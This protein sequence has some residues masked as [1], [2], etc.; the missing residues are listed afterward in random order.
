MKA[1]KLVIPIVAKDINL[2]INNIEKIKNYLKSYKLVFIGNAE[3]KNLLPEHNYIEFIDE[4]TLF[5]NLNIE[6]INRMLILKTGVGNRAG[7][8]FQQFLKM[9]YSQHC[10]DEY[11]LVWDSDTLPLEE[12]S[13]FNEDQKPYLSYKSFEKHDLP[14]F[15]TI[16]NI[17]NIEVVINPESKSYVVEHM[18]F[19]TRIMKHLISDIQSNLN[20]S[21]NTFFEKIINA[22]PFK[23]LNLSG[24]S[25]FETYVA[26]VK[27]EYPNFYICR[28]WNNLRCGKIFLGE[29]PSEKS[30][31]WVSKAFVS[32]SIERYDKEWKIF[33]IDAIR[34]MDFIHVYNFFYPIIRIKFNV[35]MFIRKY[36][37]HLYLRILNLKR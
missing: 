19:N 31:E 4:N 29:Q 8:Y 37:K 3:L 7:W 24:F 13:F 32:V 21:G 1:Y 9:A 34:K 16:K 35:R 20:L 36:F 12:I 26:F 18:L 2:V 17:F 11:Y 15:E 22:I 33:K 30:L 5:S 14:Y 28:I 6:T 25:E 27:R 10:D 23:N